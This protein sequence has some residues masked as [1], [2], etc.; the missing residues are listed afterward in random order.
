MSSCVAMSK[1]PSRKAPSPDAPMAS[2]TPYG[3]RMPR[4]L[5]DVL[6]TAARQNGR[7]LNSEIVARLQVSVQTG[8]SSPNTV[9]SDLVGRVDGLAKELETLRAQVR[10]LQIRT[11]MQG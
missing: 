8:G 2:I 5:K 7:S 1:L 6:D 3:L 9:T 11:D 10:R 4:E